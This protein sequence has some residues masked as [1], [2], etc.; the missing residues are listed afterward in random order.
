MRLLVTGTEG[1]VARAL[2]ERA[3]PGLEVIRLGRPQLELAAPVD[4]AG[5]FARHAPDVVVSAAA[6]TA[7]DRAESEPD[8]A[9]AIN[10]SGAGAVADAARALGVPVV[11]L[12]TDY[13]FDGSGSRGLLE[14]DPTGPI[15]VYGASKLAGE[16]AVAAA[17]ADHAILR[18]A[19]VY[20]PFGGNF[21]R[22]MLR[23]AGT[24]DEVRVVAD[25]HGTPTS[26]LDIAAAVEQVARNLAGRPADAALRGTFHLTA[27]GGP[28]D[29]AA[30]A[31]EIFRLSRAQGGRAPM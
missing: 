31:T 3:G 24:R 29:W 21:V 12:S 7:V 18:T 22:T 6:Y 5:L 19:W 23:L 8:L 26:A 20:A 2:A 11:H 1:Q 13:V 27:A 16:A 4:L 15:G 10:A 30:F 14:T 17:N 28:T 25:Q 9:F